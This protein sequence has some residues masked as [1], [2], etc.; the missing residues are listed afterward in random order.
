MAKTKKHEM[1]TY[2]ADVQLVEQ[3]GIYFIYKDGERYIGPSCRQ[4]PGSC[5][6]AS[7]RC[8]QRSGSPDGK[9]LWTLSKTRHS[10]RKRTMK[11]TGQKIARW[12]TLVSLVAMFGFAGIA[13][14]VDKLSPGLVAGMFLSVLAFGFFAEL[15][16]FTYKGDKL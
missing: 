2:T 11:H 10:G 3:N 12:L 8:M 4:T 15:G 9:P 5:W 6:Q 7:T 13:E 14:Q 16:G 1:H